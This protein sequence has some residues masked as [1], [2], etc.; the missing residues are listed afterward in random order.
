MDKVTVAKTEEVSHT[1]YTYL[2][3]GIQVRDKYGDLIEVIEMLHESSSFMG[4]LMIDFELVTQLDDAGLSRPCG[5]GDTM[6]APTALLDEHYEAIIEGL[7]NAQANHEK[8]EALEPIDF[9]VAQGHVHDFIW[10]WQ[11]T[12]PTLADERAEGKK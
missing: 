9:T 11:K 8:D 7:I 1:V 4:G 5:H 6:R 2:I 3:N 10:P 12:Y